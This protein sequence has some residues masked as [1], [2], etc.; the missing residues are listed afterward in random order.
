MEGARRIIRS[1]AM[2]LF[3]GLLA[4]LIMVAVTLRIAEITRS[5]FETAT[6]AQ[7]SASAAVKLRAS[8]QAAESSQRGYLLTENQIYLAPFA[9]AKEEVLRQS[10]FLQQVR[11]ASLLPPAAME[12]LKTLIDGKIAEMEQS[13]ALQRDGQRQAAEAV[14]RSNQGKALMDEANVF[15]SAIIRGAGVN[16][17]VAASNQQRGFEM[18]RAVML[19]AVVL[20]ILVS[21]LFIRLIMN[22][23]RDL[24]R[25]K[26]EVV[27]LN[28]NLEVR[29]AQRTAELQQ[30][31][32]RAELLLA[33][34]NHRVANG[35][36]MVAGMVGLQAR[37]ASDAETKRLLAE[38]QGRISAVALVHRKLYTSGDVNSVA[39]E[40]F[41]PGLLQQL[42]DSL[43]RSGDRIALNHEIDSM[44]FPTDQ[45]VS[46]GVIVT[47]WVTNAYK[48][49]YPDGA[50]EIR[51]KLR[52]L[53]DGQAELV[54]EDD[55]I[56]R[57][58]AQPARGT[59][60]GTRLVSAMTASLNAKVEYRS[61]N[62]GTSAH[63]ILPKQDCFSPARAT[64]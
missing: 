48:Y 3:V 30:S 24:N 60:L 50:G 58:E 41:L 5:D 35:L 11:S 9:A 19:A 44:K 53:P 18:L 4:L 15:L 1:A 54:V 31:R 62:P 61:R 10:D 13:I 23:V 22:F 40:E 46:I 32:D 47:E 25:V 34:V 17:A 7:N 16:L 21:T 59:G 55:G 14:V 12:R 39:L 51:V 42:E 43:R 36:A 33:E 26:D 27:L 57:S 64:A 45:T 6:F 8:L 49:A 63:L 56:G 38:T 37:S 20:I 29:V 52:D 28:R 2:L